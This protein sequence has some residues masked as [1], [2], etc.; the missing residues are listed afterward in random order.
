[1]TVR[2]SQYH[3]G[4]EIPEQSLAYRLTKRFWFSDFGVYD[5]HDHSQS[6]APGLLASEGRKPSERSAEPDVVELVIR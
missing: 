1:M 2:T 6:A 5:G 3:P 4:D